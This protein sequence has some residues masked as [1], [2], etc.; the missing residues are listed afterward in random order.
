MTPLPS[1]PVTAAPAIQTR[2]QLEAVLENIADLQRER[3][4][5]HHEQ[6]KEIALVRQ[7]YRGPLTEVENYLTSETSWVEA[8]V[9]AHPEILAADRS[10]TCAHVTIGFRAEAPRIERAS[11]RWTWSRIAETL[12]GLT[13][14]QRYLRTPPPEVDKD[15]ILGD[16]PHLSLEDLRLAGMRVAQGERFFITPHSAAEPAWREAA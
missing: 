4:A 16:L 15:A 14:G 13:W 2:E 6:E 12:A 1:L 7:R 3:D 11:R 8:W 9:L 10:L 5:L